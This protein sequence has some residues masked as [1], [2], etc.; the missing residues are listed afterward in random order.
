MTRMR[1]WP[2]RS[3]VF[4]PRSSKQS[5]E[6]LKD[7]AEGEDSFTLVRVRRDVW[8]CSTP[9]SARPLL[10]SHQTWF[11]Q[12]SP[13]DTKHVIARLKLL[14]MTLRRV[15]V[16]SN[17][18]DL[19]KAMCWWESRLQDEHLILSE[20]FRMRDH[21]RHLPLRLPARRHRQSRESR[22]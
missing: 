9:Q 18:V 7:W 17:L 8:V 1:W 4:C 22:R 19:P 16:I 6:L 5:S 20:L 15:D 11:R 12:L 13:A 21:W 14:K 3:A 10:E 2:P